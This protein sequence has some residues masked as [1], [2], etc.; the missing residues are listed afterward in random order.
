MENSERHLR[1]NERSPRA[2]LKVPYLTRAPPPLR[3]A[4]VG[5]S[6]GWSSWYF[7]PSGVCSTR[8]RTRSAACTA[9]GGHP[10]G[11]EEGRGREAGCL[12]RWQ[13]LHPQARTTRTGPQE[14]GLHS[15]KGNVVV[16]EWLSARSDSRPAP[17]PAGDP[18]FNP[19]AMQ[20]EPPD[21]RDLLDASIKQKS[22]RRKS[23]D[24]GEASCMLPGNADP[25]PTDPTRPNRTHLSQHPR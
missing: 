19:C 2:C 22:L 8:C 15:V 24:W 13:E 7:C 5:G 12:A 25:P 3:Q 17:V 1:T 6:Q 23:S 18:H 21:C 20:S 10:A 4:H 11:Q 16:P 14:G 9:L